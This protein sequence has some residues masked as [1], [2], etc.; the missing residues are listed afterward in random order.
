VGRAGA[1]SSSLGVVAAAVRADPAGVENLHFVITAEDLA[2]V[3][4]AD[5]ELVL[6]VVHGSWEDQT[7]DAS[8]QSRFAQFSFGGHFC[9]A[10]TT[11][12]PATQIYVARF[13]SCLH[14]HRG[15]AD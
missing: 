6:E 7:G 2:E 9:F 5:S 14:K 8:G 3:F 15:T 13:V 11:P 1:V 4:P 10:N 12:T